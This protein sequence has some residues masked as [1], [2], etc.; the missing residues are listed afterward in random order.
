MNVIVRHYGM[1]AYIDTL[2]RMREFVDARTPDSA[3]E[4]WFLEHQPVFTQGQGG[5]AAHVHDTGEIPLVQSDRGGQVTY[6][7]PGQLVAYILMDLRRQGLGPRELVRRIESGVISM[8]QE[9]G[10]PGQRRVGAPGVYVGDAKV[11]ALGLRIRRGMSYHGLS[12]NVDV[13]LAPFARIDPCGYRGL[14]VTRLKDLGADMDCA[15]AARCL[16]SPLLESLYREHKQ[17]AVKHVTEVS[18]DG[19]DSSGNNREHTHA[20]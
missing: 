16:L 2:R 5:R 8:L 7:G 6:H 13:D 1:V 12:L 3:D 9:L 20:L 18:P 10:V 15:A 14:E 4:I 11:A 17:V 19:R